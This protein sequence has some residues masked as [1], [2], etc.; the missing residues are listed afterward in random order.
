EYEHAPG[1]P[2]AGHRSFASGKAVGIGRGIA[3]FQVNLVVALLGLEQ[4]P[5]VDGQPARRVRVQ[6][7]DPT[8]QPVGIELVV[9]RVVEP[10]AEI[11]ALAVTADLDH[12]RP[13]VQGT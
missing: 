12:L 5:A 7:N 10:V 2:P 9:P 6:A 3:A 4:E 8:L 1:P 11:D 13:P